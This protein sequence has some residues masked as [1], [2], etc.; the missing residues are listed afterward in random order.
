MSIYFDSYVHELLIYLVLD[1]L[2]SHSSTMKFVIASQLFGM[3]VRL[4][5]GA[6]THCFKLQD[7][8]L[9]GENGQEVLIRSDGILHA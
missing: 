2:Q 6:D 7:F 1:S 9:A 4:V 3:V 8:A 5:D